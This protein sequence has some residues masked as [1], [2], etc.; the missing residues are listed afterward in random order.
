MIISIPKSKTY[1]GGVDEDSKELI[2]QTT[3]FA[4]GPLLVKYF[5]VPLV[6][7][8][9]T[10]TDCQSLIERMLV[11]LKHWSIRLLSYAGRLQL[12]KNVIFSIANYWMQIFPLPKMI[13]SH[14]DNMCSN[15][16]WYGK[17]CPIRKAPVSCDHISDPISIG[18]LNLIYLREWNKVTIEKLLWN[19]FAKKDKLWTNWIHMYYLK[20][21]EVAT[22][23]L[24]VQCS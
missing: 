4:I 10:I 18:W 22:C 9:L 11:R 8:K 24:N 14:I 1:F 19:V 23:I 12:V 17:D 2:Q 3:G 6:S 13:I 16:L 21:E 15:F 7:K 5:G 20:K